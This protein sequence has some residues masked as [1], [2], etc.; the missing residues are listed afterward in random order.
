MC[1]TMARHCRLFN[2]AQIPPSNDFF[3]SCACSC[4]SGGADV[5]LSPRCKPLSALSSL[6]VQHPARLFLLSP[7][8]LWGLIKNSFSTP[9]YS[10]WVWSLGKMSTQSEAF[11]QGRKKKKSDF[12]RKVGNCQLRQA[13]TPRESP[14]GFHSYPEGSWAPL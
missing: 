12:C 7:P 5:R 11:H 9:A 14:L 10:K 1:A 13:S 2:E 4:G 8:A 6:F 3:C